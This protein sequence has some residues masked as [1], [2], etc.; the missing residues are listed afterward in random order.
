M[1]R[2]GVSSFC[3]EMYNDWNTYPDTKDTKKR[4]CIFPNQYKYG[5]RSWYRREKGEG[6]DG[7]IGRNV[8]QLLLRN[9]LQHNTTRVPRH[10]FSLNLRYLMREDRIRFWLVLVSSFSCRDV[11]SHLVVLFVPRPIVNLARNPYP[12]LF[13]ELEGKEK[14]KKGRRGEERGNMDQNVIVIMH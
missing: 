8:Q 7:V 2:S 14:I 13:V 12:S 10:P 11:Y 3:G 4:F 9:T 1:V 5:C 6:T